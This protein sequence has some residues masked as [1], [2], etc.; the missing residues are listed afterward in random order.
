VFGQPRFEIEDYWNQALFDRFNRAY[1]ACYRE[2]R[3]FLDENGIAHKMRADG[4]AAAA[5]RRVA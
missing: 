1:Y 5:A 2:M 4:A 3:T